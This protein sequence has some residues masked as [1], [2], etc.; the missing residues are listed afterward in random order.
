MSNNLIL[1]V[2]DECKVPERTCR[3]LVSG[4]V[5]IPINRPSGRNKSTIILSRV[6]DVLI[7]IDLAKTK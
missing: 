3:C 6:A 4:G 5:F 1:F 2:K 7:R